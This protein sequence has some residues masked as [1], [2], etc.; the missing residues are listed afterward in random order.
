MAEQL[1]TRRPVSTRPGEHTPHQLFL[2]GQGDALLRAARASIRPEGGFWWLTDSGEPDPREPLHTWIACRMTHVFALAQLRQVPGTADAVDHG[3]ATLRGSLRDERHGGWFGA[4]DLR[5]EPVTDRKSAYEHAF[6][7]LAASS[8][9]RAGRPGAEHLLDE[10]LNVVNDRFWD[11]TVGR[12]RESWNRDWSESEPYRGANSSMHMVEAFLAAG[13]VTGDRRWA[14]RALTICAH[15][16]HDVAARHDWRLPEHFTSAWEPRLDYNLDRPADPFRPYGSTVGHWLEWSRLL[17]HLETALTAPPHWLLD[18]ARALFAAAVARGWAADGADG[19]V[20]TL[21][22]ADRP[23]VRSRMHWVLAEAIGAAAT[24]WRRT[25]DEFYEHWYHVFWDYA[26]RH[27]I[28]KATGHWRHELDEANRPSSMVWHGR[29][30]FYHA[31]QAVLLSQSPIA[32]SLAGL[33]DPVPANP[34][35]VNR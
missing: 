11:E 1:P 23:V 35:E 33:Y 30:D 26:V 15:L 28:D 17:L 25:G 8:A 7:L 5:G 10:V 31:Y 27:L 14:Q 3:V 32:P 21:D 19:F 16:V 4:V 9:T 2:T 13:D 22:W 34:E 20:Y 24:L 29:P 6:V 12:T 18:D